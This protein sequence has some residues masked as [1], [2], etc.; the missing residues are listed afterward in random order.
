[1]YFSKI[2]INNLAEPFRNLIRM[3][4]SV[5]AYQTFQRASFASPVFLEICDFI[6]VL[7][8]PL[9]ELNTLH[10]LLTMGSCEHHF[11]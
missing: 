4:F 8:L 7:F 11:S 10:I 6:L 2:S 1:M 3:Q 5:Q 9:K